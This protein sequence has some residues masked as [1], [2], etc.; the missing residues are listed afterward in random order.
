[1]L[2]GK[3]EWGDTNLTVP[4][5]HLPNHI[6]CVKEY[7]FIIY[8][9]FYCNVP[10]FI[11]RRGVYFQF[12]LNCAWCVTGLYQFS[13]H[14]STKENRCNL[15]F[16]CLIGRQLGRVTVYVDERSVGLSSFC[17]F[18]FRCSP[19][20]LFYSQQSFILF[21]SPTSEYLLLIPRTNLT[22][23]R[24]SHWLVEPLA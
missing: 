8:F 16:H 4:N 3:I 17:S 2:G 1:M 5:Y 11:S 12:F 14:T 18:S 22:E 15:A 23:C 24:K 13:V 6:D 9:A 20:S 19:P 7:L 21:Y 10:V